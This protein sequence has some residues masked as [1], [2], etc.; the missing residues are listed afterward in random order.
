MDLATV[1]LNYDLCDFVTDYDLGG[2]MA[3]SSSEEK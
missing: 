2:G 1:C 3:L